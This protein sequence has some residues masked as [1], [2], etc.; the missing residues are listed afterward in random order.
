MPSLKFAYPYYSPPP[1][2]F[3]L[4]CIPPVCICPLPPQV[5]TLP[6]PSYTPPTAPPQPPAYVWSPPSPDFP[7]GSPAYPPP[8]SYYPYSPEISPSPLSAAPH[9]AVADNDTTVIA[10]AVSLGGAFFLAV[11]AI[12]LC[13]CLAKMK[14]KPVLIPALAPV[15]APV[16]AESTRCEPLE[17]EEKE[18]GFAAATTSYSPVAAGGRRE[19]RE[20]PPC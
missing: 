11:L 3:P 12:G 16:P 8:S 5:A 1:L 19:I 2:P 14:K 13:C 7:V 15:P 6:P 20:P 17:I 10:V 18:E 4:P 9:G